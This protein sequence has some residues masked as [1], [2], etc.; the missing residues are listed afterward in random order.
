[1]AKSRTL[2]ITEFDLNRLDKLIET[3]E[4]ESEM[5]D[6]KYLEDLGV[7][8]HRA[9]IIAP[10]DI[11]HDVITMNTRVRVKDLESGEEF[12]YQVVFPESADVK[13]NKISVLAPIGTA[14]IGFSAGDTVEWEVPARV[15]RLKIEEVLYQP[16]A[17]GDF[18][19]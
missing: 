16:E 6:R 4:E 15:R 12:I 17:T 18:H 11:P 10:K 19:L 2:Y 9:K 1:M 14:L 7:E 5:R 13:Q 3:F 8:L